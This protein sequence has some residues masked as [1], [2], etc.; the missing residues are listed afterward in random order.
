MQS[1]TECCDDRC[2]HRE[3]HDQ[4]DLLLRVAQS[5]RRKWKLDEREKHRYCCVEV[6]DSQGLLRWFGAEC[7][8]LTE[9]TEGLSGSIVEFP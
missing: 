7:D 3:D 5:L 2:D 8:E 6:S 4:R 1:M 9:A